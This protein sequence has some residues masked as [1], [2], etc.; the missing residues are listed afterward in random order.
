MVEGDL[1]RHPYVIVVGDARDDLVAQTLRL[2]GEYEVDV[3]RCDDIYAAVA[4]LAAPGH[5]GVL[6]VGRFRELARQRGRLFALAAR[7]RA[8]SCCLLESDASA[9]Q[10]DILSAVRAGIVL[11]GCVEEIEPILEDWL[12]CNGGRQ[13]GPGRRGLTDDEF[14]ATE[15]ELNALLG[16][17][18]DG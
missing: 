6:L 3:T 15:A 5:G 7:H 12:A 17:E 2:A 18:V 10:G 8:R 9:R 4:E 14:R 11:V 16:R 13:S 1:A